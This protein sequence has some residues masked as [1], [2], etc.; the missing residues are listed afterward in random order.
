LNVTFPQT[1]FCDKTAR[2]R[3]SFDADADED[4]VKTT[5]TAKRSERQKLCR[6]G[7]NVDLDIVI[8]STQSVFEFST[9]FLMSL[10][11]A[12]AVSSQTWEGR[13]SDRVISVQ[14]LF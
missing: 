3:T 4:D 5:N 1:P 2:N 10:F 11:G 12:A 14:V 13:G 6:H 7:S 8:F 9:F